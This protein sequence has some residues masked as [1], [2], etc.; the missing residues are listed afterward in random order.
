MQF[1]VASPSILGSIGAAGWSHPGCLIAEHPRKGG[2]YLLIPLW[3]SQSNFCRARVSFRTDIAGPWPCLPVCAQF[4][5]SLS[6]FC[7][8]CISYPIPSSSR[9][10][11]P[12]TVEPRLK[13]Q[14]PFLLSRFRHV[15]SLRPVAAPDCSRRANKLLWLVL[16]IIFTKRARNVPWT[17][18]FSL[19]LCL[20]LSLS[21]DHVNLFLS[22]SDHDLS[23]DRWR[24]LP[25]LIC[26]YLYFLPL[27]AFPFTFRII[28]NLISSLY[29][30]SI[31]VRIFRSGSIV[32]LLDLLS[33]LS[34]G[35]GLPIVSQERQTDDNQPEK[36]LNW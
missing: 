23:C 27:Q 11:S 21:H 5:L 33:C 30:L 29:C 28:F 22:L 32:L 26:L 6:F 13:V 31:P 25:W 34:E 9:P 14:L 36:R 8:L 3:Q 17:L 4:P 20:V 1:I 2:G 16:Q 15:L 7:E 12:S 24:S 19:S 35:V 18:S 10:A